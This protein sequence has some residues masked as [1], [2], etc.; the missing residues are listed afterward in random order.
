MTTK[1]HTCI[2]NYSS[3]LAINHELGLT[4]L[5]L[6]Q[7]NGTFY[8]HVWASGLSSEYQARNSRLWPSLPYLKI[9]SRKQAVITYLE[10]LRPLKESSGQEGT[11]AFQVVMEI[12][13]PYALWETCRFHAGLVGPKNRVPKNKKNKTRARYVAQW[14]SA[15]LLGKCPTTEP[16]FQSFTGRF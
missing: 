4:V 7:Y 3:F 15:Y 1:I 9:N 5:S 16:Y 8:S 14:W 11:Q 2:S 12:V 13:T 10:T 6:D